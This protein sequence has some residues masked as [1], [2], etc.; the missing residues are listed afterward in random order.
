MCR[1]KNGVR[2]KGLEMRYYI[3][4]QYFSLSF[5]GLVLMLGGLSGVP[6]GI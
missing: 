3:H 5:F 6:K 1:R 4:L 2:S